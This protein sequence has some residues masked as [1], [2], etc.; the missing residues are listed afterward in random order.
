MKERKG[1]KTMRITNLILHIIAMVLI[2]PDLLFLGINS[3][4]GLGYCDGFELIM[5]LTVDM[6]FC[7]ACTGSTVGA[8]ILCATYK[9]AKP[10]LYKIWEFVIH[11]L[12][13]L[14]YGVAILYMINITL[15]S[16]SK[17]SIFSY[18]INLAGLGLCIAGIVV[19]A[20][21]GRKNKQAK[22]IAQPQVAAPVNQS[23]PHQSL[24]RPRFCSKCGKP[25]GPNG[26]FCGNAAQN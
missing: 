16:S 13:A 4:M 19:T 14:C 10:K 17:P 21:G 1:N 11:G 22:V 25:V 7:A 5:V 20:A 24:T 23:V 8:I 12:T 26:G 18:V 9:P 3:L 6:L 15:N 2:L